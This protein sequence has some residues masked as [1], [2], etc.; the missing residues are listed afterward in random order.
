[1]F[2]KYLEP[3]FKPW[4]MM[5]SSV[6]RVRT[7]KGN[8]VA[9]KNRVGR[10]GNMARSQVGKVQG[11]MAQAQGQAP[12]LPQGQVGPIP[13]QGG[14][15]QGQIPGHMP[16]PQQMP[17]A[18]MPGYPGQAP[19]MPAAGAP[20]PG[21]PMPGQMGAPPPLNPNPPIKKVGFFRRRKVCTQCNTELDKTWDSCPY[22]AQAAAPHQPEARKTKA[23]RVDVASGASV[24]ILGWLVPIEGPQR[25]ELYTLA[26]CSVIGTDPMTCQIV[27][28]DTYMSSKHAEI[29]AEGGNW[30][31]HD[32]GSTN[33][34]YVNDR[35]VEQHELVDN[36]FVKFGKSV[37]KFKSL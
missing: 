30:I 25:G 9:E 37:L 6:Q 35:R 36:D 26:P 14:Q 2:L 21:M 27:L 22:C 20:M 1:M 28:T 24:Q 23:F 7:V 19:G 33:G 4:R 29:R 3:I 13:G 17:N 12:Q 31:L 34:T 32:L 11:H 15:M 16:P 8:I 10:F 5:R 18:Q